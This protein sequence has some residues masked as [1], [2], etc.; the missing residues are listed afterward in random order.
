MELAED[1]M[2]EEGNSGILITAQDQ[3][4]RAINI[5][6]TIDQRTVSPPMWIVGRKTGHN[7]QFAC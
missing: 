3:A 2:V 1:K 7:Q 4:L 6:S 5:Q